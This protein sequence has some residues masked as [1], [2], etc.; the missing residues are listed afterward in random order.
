MPKQKGGFVANRTY[1]IITV[2]GGLGGS[3]LA[4]VMAEHG[5]RVLVVEREREF[6]DRVRGEGMHAWGVPEARALGIYDL[7]SETCGQEA[8]WW[9]TYLG[10]ELI[11][12]RDFIATT[13]HHSPLFS[14]Y[15]PEMQEVLLTAA[16]KAGAEVRRGGTI[17]EVKPGAFPTVAIEQQG[18][19]EEVRARL[20]VGADGRTS[21]VRKWAG[22]P[23]QHDP[24]RQFF[25]G[26]LFENM[27]VPQDTWYGILNP[28]IGQ[29][30]ALANVGQ[31][32]VR[33]YLGYPKDAHRRFQGTADIPR[34][35]EES[36]RT[37]A[38]A[39]LYANAHAIG[40]LATFE[41]DD[42]WVEHPYRAGVALIGDAATTCDPTFGQGLALTLR[43]V[44]VLRDQL[45]HHD[46]WEAAG[47]VYA[48]LHDRDYHAIH[49]AEDW[50]RAMFL[51]TGPEADARRAKALPLIA[52]DG[53]RMPDLYGLGP[54]V[55][56]SETA[57]RRF[58]GEE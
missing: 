24:E 8:R 17:R 55:P 18:Q 7:L 13:P 11:D 58:F 5:A 34:F 45:L 21:L 23:V 27:S 20:V 28:K 46:D 44:R 6:K 53:T 39:E 57:R 16:A 37:G 29:L 40:P 4:K 32:R 52:Q 47:H 50:L 35:I 15:H 48:E 49:T 14:F 2:G 22:F 3:S 54:E 10:S 36:L 42:T 43:S 9:D 25:T 38:A 41:A 33:A 31:G 1:D 19:V 56:T 12:H 30:V 51:E 26:A